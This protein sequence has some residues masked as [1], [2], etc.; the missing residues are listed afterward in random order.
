MI[1]S[2][3][4]TFPSISCS[5]FSAQISRLFSTFCPTLA[6]PSP[7]SL[8]RFLNSKARNNRR[9][10][11]TPTPRVTTSTNPP[12]HCTSCHWYHDDCL[13]SAKTHAQ[14]EPISLSLCQENTAFS[15]FS[16]TA[17]TT[18]SILLFLA[19][20]SEMFCMCKN[21]KNSK[22]NCGGVIIYS[23]L[24][25]DWQWPSCTLPTCTP[26]PLVFPSLQWKVGVCL[27]L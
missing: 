5:T 10:A 3:T 18:F 12:H 22:K 16:T 11:S 23:G 2:V 4:V 14:R 20:V 13:G 6:P 1:H 15:C 17:I 9:Q 19:A 7:L 26:L 25:Q 8:S 24:Q 27:C 21:R